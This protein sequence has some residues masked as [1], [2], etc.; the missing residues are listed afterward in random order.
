MG[1]A[2]GFSEP[3]EFDLATLVGNA[4]TAKGSHRVELNF[5]TQIL[6]PDPR[7]GLADATAIW[8]GDLT[9]APAA[10]E[11]VALRPEQIVTS[12]DDDG[13]DAASAFAVRLSAGRQTIEIFP[14]GKEARRLAVP[15]SNPRAKILVTVK[16]NLPLALAWNVA[17]PKTKAGNRAG[18]GR[19]SLH[20][21]AKKG[22]SHRAG[23]LDLTPLLGEGPR[24]I[25][26]AIELVPS[27]RAA[28]L[29]PQIDTFWNLRL[30]CGKVTF[31][32]GS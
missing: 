4:V 21:G 27:A 26:L 8:S 29:N 23:E 1:K 18:L 14:P 12:R 2:L 31:E 6:R 25:T 13:L 22:M 7:T 20:A 16:E 10:F 5:R 30:D 3:I 24:S 28:Y 9:A 15:F 32:T 17:G 11:V 19:L